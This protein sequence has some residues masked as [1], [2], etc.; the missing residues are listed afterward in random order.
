MKKKGEETQGM[1]IEVT[2]NYFHEPNKDGVSKT[3]ND[4][5]D[6]VYKKGV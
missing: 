6:G 3:P 5:G 2:R 1:I 4:K